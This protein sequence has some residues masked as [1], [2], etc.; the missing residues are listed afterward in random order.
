MLQDEIN[1][2]KKGYEE[3]LQKYNN[4]RQLFAPLKDGTLKKRAIDYKFDYP[5]LKIELVSEAKAESLKLEDNE[6]GYLSISRVIFNKSFDKGYLSFSFWCGQG[7]AW[8][9]NVGIS[10]INGK[11]KV[12]EHFSGYIA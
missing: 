12:T 2:N 9:N 8:G 7:C 5:N 3:D 6:Y 1:Q 4:E 10:K 11:W